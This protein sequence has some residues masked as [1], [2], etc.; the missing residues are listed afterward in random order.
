LASCGCSGAIDGLTTSHPA[1]GVVLALLALTAGALD[2]AAAG[3]STDVCAPS[4]APVL[5]TG[6][7][8]FNPV[9]MREEVVGS[10]ALAQSVLPFGWPPTT[11]CTGITKAAFFTAITKTLEMQ[12]N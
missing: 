11:S 1:R 5:S 3:V 8:L 2:A 6:H 10:P 7:C 9:R 4:T 12:R